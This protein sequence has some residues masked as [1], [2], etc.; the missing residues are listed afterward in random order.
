MNI[1]EQM[2][3]AITY[4]IQSATWI[5]WLVVL[6]LAAKSIQS[7]IRAYK[8]N[9]SY[10]AMKVNNDKTGLSQFYYAVILSITTVVVFF[11]PYLVYYEG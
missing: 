5:T 7:F 2:Q 3:I 6:F 9:D 8:E 10:A 4:S 11:L 1:F